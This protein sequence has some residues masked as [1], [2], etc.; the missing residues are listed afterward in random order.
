MKS[1][2]QPLFAKI[3]KKVDEL[4]TDAKGTGSP[5]NFIFMVGGFSESPYLKAHIKS[6]FEAEKLAIFVPKRP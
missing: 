2:F 1:F 4:L 3:E 5:V 6:K